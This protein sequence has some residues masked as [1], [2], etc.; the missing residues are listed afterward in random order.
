MAPPSAP[1]APGI[2][3]RRPHNIHAL[4]RCH[5][6]SIQCCSIVPWLKSLAAQG[7][8]RRKTRLSCSTILHYLSHLRIDIWVSGSRRSTRTR[9][10]APTLTHSVRFVP[11]PQPGPECRIRQIIFLFEHTHKVYRYNPRYKFQKLDGAFD[12]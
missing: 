8:C 5:V 3:C 9:A 10:P 1:T 6:Q 2:F 11:Q 7:C 4:T 12:V